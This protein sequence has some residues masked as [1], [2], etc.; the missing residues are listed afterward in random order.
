MKHPATTLLLDGEPVE[1]DVEIA[2]LIEL[3]WERDLFTYNS[4]QDLG[5]GG[6]VW[7]EFDGPSA[8]SFLNLVA[9]EAEELRDAIVG[10]IPEEEV[11]RFEE[12]RR[13]R[14]WRYRTLPHRFEDG[15]LLFLLSVEFP[16]SDLAAV[17]AALRRRRDLDAG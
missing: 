3:L 15:E 8:E 6:F 2:P 14:H 16:R 17:V 1:I 4:C 12:Y 13:E 7:V 5:G 11:D 10:H 9:S